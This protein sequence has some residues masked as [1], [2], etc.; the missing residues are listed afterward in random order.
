[1]VI[2]MHN[3]HYKIA[4]IICGPILIRRLIKAVSVIIPGEAGGLGRQLPGKWPLAIAP[5]VSRLSCI[6][7]FSESLNG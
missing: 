3:N 2:L 7:I 6:S 1:M 5:A 4:N